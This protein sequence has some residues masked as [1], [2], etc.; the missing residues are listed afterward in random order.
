MSI[1]KE[2]LDDTEFAK[3]HIMQMA[4]DEKCKKTLISLLNNATIATN[5]I[6]IEE[7]VQKITESIVGLVV[8]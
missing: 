8:S 7:K 4:V 3:T 5:G 1:S 2:I 6:S